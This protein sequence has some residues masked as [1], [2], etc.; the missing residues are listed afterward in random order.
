MFSQFKGFPAFNMKNQ[1]FH[2]SGAS[3]LGSCL[4]LGSLG[5]IHNPTIICNGSEAISK[6]NANN[7]SNV[8]LVLK[9]WHTFDWSKSLC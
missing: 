6:L 2:P 8:L 7:H 3:T 5:C 9:S 1:T 4:N